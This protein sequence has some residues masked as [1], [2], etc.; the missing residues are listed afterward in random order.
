MGATQRGNQEG[1]GR[2]QEHRE[3]KGRG[4]EHREHLVHHFHDWRLQQVVVQSLRIDVC[5]RP[6]T[7]GET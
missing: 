3:G 4:Q 7:E 1:T 6:E 5:R 2:G